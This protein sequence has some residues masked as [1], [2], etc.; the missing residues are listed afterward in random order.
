[1]PRIAGCNPTPAGNVAMESPKWTRIP[2]ILMSTNRSRVKIHGSKGP[3]VDVS[4]DNTSARRGFASLG[5][6][7]AASACYRSARRPKP[8]EEGGGEVEFGIPAV[9]L[10]LF[11]EAAG[12]WCWWRTA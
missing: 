12:C 5:A 6:L 9:F 2:P 8:S 1:M 3:K 11:A 7:G 10:A 4:P